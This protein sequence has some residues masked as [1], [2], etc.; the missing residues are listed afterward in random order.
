MKREFLSPGQVENVVGEAHQQYLKGLFGLWRK[1]EHPDV[2]KTGRPV[3]REI[4]KREL[5]GLMQ[6]RLGEAAKLMPGTE[7]HADCYSPRSS[8]ALLVAVAGSLVKGGQLDLLGKVLGL[9]DQGLEISLEEKHGKTHFD[10]VLRSR[11]GHILATIE[12]KF[13]EP[14]LNPCHYPESSK[15]HPTPRC[16]GTWR[17]R[18]GT[19]LGCPMSASP[20]NRNLAERY[21]GVL[22]SDWDLP[23]KPPSEPMMCPLR[24][25]YQAVHNLAETRR[26]A[27]QATWV[28]LYDERNPY[29]GHPEV[30]CVNYLTSMGTRQWRAV[31]W[32]QSIGYLGDRLPEAGRR[33]V[34]LQGF[35]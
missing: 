32:Q 28:L 25:V 21:W 27:P 3:G 10:G 18:S 20:R 11:G 24:G 23:A 19:R 9:D 12:A 33:F 34:E 17:D 26:M 1:M 8:Q 13:T 6:E 4:S 29:F 22:Q 7:W 15:K 2:D 14:G 31:S 5:P 30:G 16:D 35:L